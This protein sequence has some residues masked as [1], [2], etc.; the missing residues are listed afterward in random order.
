[1]ADSVHR[2]FCRAILED[3]QAGRVEARPVAA[4]T[5]PGRY[6]ASSMGYCLCKMA[7]LTGREKVLKGNQLPPCAIHKALQTTRAV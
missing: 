1:M 3:L 2:L 4:H 6:R 7:R 5:D